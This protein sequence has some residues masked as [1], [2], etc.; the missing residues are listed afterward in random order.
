MQ[1]PLPSFQSM[2]SAGGPMNSASALSRPLRTGP[3]PSCTKPMTSGQTIGS[4]PMPGV[5]VLYASASLSD[6][7]NEN[8]GK[9]QV[10]D[11]RALAPSC[12]LRHRFTICLSAM[13]TETKILLNPEGGGSRKAH[14]RIAEEF[15]L[16]SFF[17]TT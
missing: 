12:H 15:F 8:R 1:P 5:C 3:S 10:K 2:R 17:A 11:L 14:L 13:S 9:M 4:K 16:V 7:R 6:G